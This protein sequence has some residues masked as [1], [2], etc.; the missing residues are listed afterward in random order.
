[1]HGHTSEELARKTKDFVSA[2][3]EA[4]ITLN[5][6]IISY[7]KPEVV[8]G[9]YL[10]SEAGYSIDPSFTTTLSEFPVPK[11]QTDIRSF[12]GLANQMCN[13]SDDI[14]EALAP[15]NHLLKKGQKF[16][17]NDDIQATFEAAR[18]HLTSTKTLAFYRPDRKS[19]LIT[20]ASRLNGI[21]FVFKQETD[22]ILKPVQAGS[23][24]LTKTEGR[25]TMVK[26]EL[27]AICWATKKCANFIDGLP[28]KLFK[29]WTD[30][31]PLIPILNKYTLPKIENKRLQ[32]LRAKLDHL[33][34][35][36]VW[37]KGSD[38]TEA[39]VLSRIPHRKAGKKHINEDKTTV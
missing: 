21:G 4:G 8:F 12:C 39:D 13:F 7:N 2:C 16:E 34:F 29:I 22:I 10:I 26:L 28:L 38:N 15:F 24:F 1:V 3:A 19:R 36:A 11:L 5:N 31:A 33:Q 30:H 9:G 6:K 25:Y 23:R 20:N 35:H 32:R 17:W 18:C 27:L 14:S 37:I